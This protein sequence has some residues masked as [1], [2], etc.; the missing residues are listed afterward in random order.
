MLDQSFRNLERVAK[1]FESLE[2]LYSSYI[3]NSVTEY[4]FQNILYDAWN[5]KKP[6]IP[7]NASEW[8]LG[9]GDDREEVASIL[10]E[11]ALEAVKELEIL[12]YV[13]R[14][15]DELTYRVV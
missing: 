14:Y 13:K 11:T 5:D 6:Y 8:D 1:K 4:I 2:V 12:K 9:E 7:K 15:I 10:S 3:R